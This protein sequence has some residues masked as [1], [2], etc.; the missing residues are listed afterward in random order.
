MELPTPSCDETNSDFEGIIS[1][2]RP[3]GNRSGSSLTQFNGRIC[4]APSTTKT[5]FQDLILFDPNQLNDLLPS[6]FIGCLEVGVVSLGK[7]GEL[8]II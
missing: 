8:R 2:Y 4:T 5:L 3:L 6:K 1:N 7:I